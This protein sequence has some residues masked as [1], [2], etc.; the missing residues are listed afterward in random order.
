MAFTAHGSNFVQFTAGGYYLSTV[1][2]RKIFKA[3]FFSTYGLN[4]SIFMPNS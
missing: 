4:L 3:N 1:V 2:A